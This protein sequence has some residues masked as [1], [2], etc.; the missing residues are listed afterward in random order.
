MADQ[1]VRATVSGS[2]RRAMPEIQLAV[3]ALVDAGVTVLSPADPRVVDQFGEFLFVASDRVRTIR[4]V[5]GRHLAAIA[6]SNFLWLVSPEGYVGPSAS[7][8]IGFAIARGIPVFGCIPPKDL[9]IRQYVTIAPDITAAVAFC[10]R[11]PQTILE[12]EVPNLLLAPDIAVDDAQQQL[13]IVRHRLTTD[14]G[15]YAE[16]SSELQSALWRVRKIAKSG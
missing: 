1:V 8:E 7:M 2:F 4:I 9:T 5:Q 11:G 3:Q 15:F 6:R 16:D 10:G 14:S 12:L 13:E